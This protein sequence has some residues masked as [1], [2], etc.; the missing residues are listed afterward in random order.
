MVSRVWGEGVEEG[1]GEGVEEGVGE[2]VEEGV[3]KHGIVL[4]FYFLREAGW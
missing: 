1:V 3:C 2:G 4:S